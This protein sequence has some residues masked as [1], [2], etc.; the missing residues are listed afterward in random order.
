MVQLNVLIRQIQEIPVLPV[1]YIYLATD[2][3]RCTYTFRVIKSRDLSAYKHNLHR[4]LPY[5]S[6]PN[7]SLQPLC[8][9]NL[10]QVSL[11]N[12]YLEISVKQLDYPMFSLNKQ[13]NMNKDKIVGMSFRFRPKCHILLYTVYS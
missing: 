5:V 13:F 2:K 9:L 4:T 10:L 8:R 3:E 7:I 1:Y 12:E 6:Q 11:F